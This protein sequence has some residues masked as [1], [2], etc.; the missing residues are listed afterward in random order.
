[1]PRFKSR[2]IIAVTSPHL[3]LEGGFSKNLTLASSNSMPPKSPSLFLCLDS[4]F[5]DL[6][7]D[8]GNRR[9][10]EEERQECRQ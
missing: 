2:I 8:E 1:M 9:R 6:Q 5:L 7:D 4:R 3:I 10:G